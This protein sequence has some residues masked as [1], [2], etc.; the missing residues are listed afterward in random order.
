MTNSQ[1]KTGKRKAEILEWGWE[2]GINRHYVVRLWEDGRHI[3]DRPMITNGVAHSKSYAEDCAE[4][5][6]DYVF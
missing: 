4:N 6:E 2:T 1:C 5:W 3:E